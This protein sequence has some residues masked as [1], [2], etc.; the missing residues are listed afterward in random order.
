MDRRSP[1]PRPPARRQPGARRGLHGG[2][3]LAWLALLGLGGCAGTAS[4]QANT[5]VL[6]Q[7]AYA[8]NG[9]IHAVSVA[10]DQRLT[11]MLA[12]RTAEIQP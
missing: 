9:T 4:P 11:R 5:A 6:V 1:T 3:V 7:Q 2:A 12:V 8:E 10:L